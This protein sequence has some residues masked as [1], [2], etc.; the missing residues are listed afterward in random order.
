MLTFPFRRL[1]ISTKKRQKGNKKRGSTRLEVLP[2]LFLYAVRS[3]MSFST[4]G[5]MPSR[6]LPPA[7]AKCG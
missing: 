6:F 2:L 1:A 3:S 4:A 5:R 7:V